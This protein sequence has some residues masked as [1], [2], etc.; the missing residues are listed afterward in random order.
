MRLAASMALA[1]V[2]I[3]CGDDDSAPQ[4]MDEPDA[5]RSD[6]GGK[7]G[8]NDRDGGER[9]AASDVAPRDPGAMMQPL[10][11]A[12]GFCWELPAPQGETLRAVWG[13]AANDVWA[14]GDGGVVLHFD[15]S[16]FTAAERAT[17]HDLLAVHGSSASDVW[18]VGQGGVVLHFDGDSWTAMDLGTLIDASGGAM[19]G[20]LYGVF[21]AGPDV[22]WA[23]GH[24]GVAA[25]IARYDGEQWT[26]EALAMPV[27]RVLRA[28]W[29]SSTEK[30][31]AVGDGGT[32]LAFDG[33]QWAPQRG[34]TNAHLVSV[35]G[36]TD[37]DVW[38]VGAAGSAVHWNGTEWKAANMGLMGMGDLSCV[39][40]DV[41][42]VP[43]PA[44]AGMAMSEPPPMMMMDAG[45]DAGLPPAPEGPWL[46]WAF[47][48]DGRVY[49]YNG[50]LWSALPSG[51]ERP[52]FGAARL[53]AGELLAVGEHGELVRFSGDARHVLS[54]GVMR[55]HLALWGDG[56][57]LWSVGDQVARR[58]QERWSV[59]ERPSDRSLYGVWGDDSG[60]WA[61]GTAGTVV[62]IEDGTPRV[63]DVPAAKD[64]W[65]RAVWGAGSSVWLV[66][67]GGLTMTNA[68]G[69]FL[70]IDT[71]VKSNLVD[72]WGDAEDHFWAVG[73][74]GIVLRWDGSAWLKVP[75]GAMGGVV[76]NL[77]AVWGSGKDDVWV[78]GVESTILH[79]DGKRF[80]QQS[81]GLTYSL[82]D[83]W[84]TAK[85][86][87]YAVG[88]SG[89]VLHYDGK[90]WTELESGTRSAL[91]SVH[92]DADGRIFAAGQDG[93][94]LVR[95]PLD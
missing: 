48:N 15:G 41:D 76:T 57:Q 10:C 51:T 25:V 17:D 52:L 3:A 21:A 24:S 46:A 38:A 80:E 61:V 78:V 92:G 95:E 85:N 42:T 74:G 5:A 62:R 72:V 14:V 77:R 55:N 31:W 93:V 22:V 26:S 66:G 79:W 84:G 20:D 81:R 36:L 59:L 90:A 88:T 23:V 39:R 11:S 40:V 87:V 27:T 56:V 32:V 29:G 30:V 70:A 91:E 82:N 67:H 89:V 6:S 69:G 43:P 19:T 54:H 4:D 68:G 73:D 53:D 13:A 63:V 44:D 50:T 71:K 16:V 35:H 8:A 65:L 60:L 86:D 28:V 83:V 64:T 94:M 34:G 9:D 45:A 7:P 47:A 33:V 2:L 12:D 1:C 58:A 75:T 18:A 37:H 49:R